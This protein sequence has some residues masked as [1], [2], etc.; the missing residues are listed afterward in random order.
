MRKEL[1]YL[2]HWDWS[3]GNGEI[4]NNGVHYL[5]KVPAVLGPW[6]TID[7]E[8]EKFVGEFA[9]PANQ[10]SRRQYREPFTVPESV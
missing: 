2:W 9:E 3:T 7:T 4:G 6:V 8:T 5:D 1:H 10:L